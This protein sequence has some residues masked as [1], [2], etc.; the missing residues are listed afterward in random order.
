[1]IQIYM[2]T[3]FNALNIGVNYQRIWKSVVTLKA[4]SGTTT[5]R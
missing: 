3:F 1:M 4:V 2:F 5:S